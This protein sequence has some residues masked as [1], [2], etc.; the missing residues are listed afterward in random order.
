M[1]VVTCLN[2]EVVRSLKVLDVFLVNE[3]ILRCY[4][5]NFGSQVLNFK[6]NDI[7]VSF[8]ANGGLIDC[9]TNQVER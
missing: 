1:T 4:L 8:F 6:F 5:Q 3:V 9:F 2:S 7:V